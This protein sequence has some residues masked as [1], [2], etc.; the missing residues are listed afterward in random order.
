MRP[1][2]GFA[3]VLFARRELA[4]SVREARNQLPHFTGV[5]GVRAQQLLL[6]AE[7]LLDLV[8]SALA[9][10]WDQ[11]SAGQP[12]LGDVLADVT[13]SAGREAAPGGR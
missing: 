3:L 8:P 9:A 5:R 10:A 11:R 7:L 12:H 2:N 13:S 6:E 1:G 4:Q